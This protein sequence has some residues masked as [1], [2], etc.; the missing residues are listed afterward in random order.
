MRSVFY[1]HE[2]R[3]KYSRRERYSGADNGARRLGQ[4]LC[5]G[6]S[7]WCSTERLLIDIGEAAVAD[8]PLHLSSGAECGFSS[9]HTEALID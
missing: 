3:T 1:S 5:V 4:L 2:T 7:A 8:A 9:K 6:P